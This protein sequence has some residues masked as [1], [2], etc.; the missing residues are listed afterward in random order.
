[1][2][3]FG[4]ARFAQAP[5]EC[6]QI[7]RHTIGRSAIKKADHRHGRLL[8][9][10]RQWPRSYRASEQRDELAAPHSITSLA[11]TCTVSGMDRPSA[12]GV[13]RLITVSNFV[14]CRTGRSAGLVPLRTFPV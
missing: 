12:L 13:L 14:G 10:R 1:V 6:G 4:V 7:V 9:A 2:L 8:R 3:A 11:E 5:V